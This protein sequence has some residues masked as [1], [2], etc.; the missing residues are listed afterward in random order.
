MLSI[1]AQQVTYQ[2]E[3][4]HSIHFIVSHE[5]TGFD[6]VTPVL[7]SLGSH[8]VACRA[9]G[10]HVCPPALLHVASVPA[11]QPVFSLEAQRKED[12]L[13]HRTSCPAPSVGESGLRQGPGPTSQWETSTHTLKGWHCGASLGGQPPRFI[14]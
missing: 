1:V 13:S 7:E 10:L 14:G 8:V 6:W 3:W 4:L 5:S 12:C 2:T 9:A 11:E